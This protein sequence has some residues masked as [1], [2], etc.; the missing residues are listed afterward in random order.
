MELV[1]LR[2]NQLVYHLQMIVKYVPQQPH[3]DVV[4]LYLLINKHKFMGLAKKY[5]ILGSSQNP[6]KV[7]LTIKSVGILIIPLVIY[8]GRLFGLEIVEA[9]LVQVLNAV[10]GIA[11]AVGVIWGIARKYK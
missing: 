10:A 9:D 11:A 2:F 6:E 1:L 3:Q 5:P 8:I 4:H 7:S